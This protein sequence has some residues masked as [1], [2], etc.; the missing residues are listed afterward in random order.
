MAGVTFDFH[1]RYH[2]LALT[3]FACKWFLTSGGGGGV[4]MIVKLIKNKK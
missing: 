1:D 3:W 2:Y 4:C